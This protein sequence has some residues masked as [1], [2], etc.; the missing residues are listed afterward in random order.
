ML[1][2]CLS[3]QYKAGCWFVGGDDFDWIFACLTAP[4]VITTSIILSSNII[5]N[6][7]I[8]V[9]AN[10]G[11]PRKMAVKWTEQMREPAP[12]P[13]PTTITDYAP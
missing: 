7:D 12:P 6:A 2:F 5:Q 1:D 11:P 3:N 4:V 8:L 9:S 13:F 10:P